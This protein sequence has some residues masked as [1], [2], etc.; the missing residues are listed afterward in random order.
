M[1][2][3]GG[4]AGAPTCYDERMCYTPPEGVTIMCPDVKNDTDSGGGGGG[5]EG[6]GC[7]PAYPK[8][9]CN[10]N[11]GL[12]CIKYRYREDGKWECGYEWN[13]GEGGEADCPDW[14]Q[15]QKDLNEKIE[16]RK[17]RKDERK[18]MRDEE[19]EANVE[20]YMKPPPAHMGEDE[21][22]MMISGSASLTVSAIVAAASSYIMY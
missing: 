2:F 16:V 8:N 1:S 14:D 5:W 13:C 21:A 19:W 6:S 7:E 15:K 11:D 12:T 18:R 3:S 10:E 4:E 9:M 22:D 20:D 17:Q